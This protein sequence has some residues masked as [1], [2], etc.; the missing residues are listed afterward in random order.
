MGARVVGH[1]LIWPISEQRAKNVTR[2]VYSVAIRLIMACED[3]MGCESG[4]GAVP[5]LKRLKYKFAV[6]SLFQLMRTCIHK[7]R[8]QSHHSQ[9][10]AI[11]SE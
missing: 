9:Y 5:R 10:M 11:V 2:A 4:L 7:Y 8:M 3:P 1:S 6:V